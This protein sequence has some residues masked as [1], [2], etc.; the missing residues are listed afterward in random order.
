MTLNREE[1]EI[2]RNALMLQESAMLKDCEAYKAQKDTEA[3]ND[4]IN[5]WR[6]TH[7]LGEKVFDE[8]VKIQTP[9]ERDADADYRGNDAIE[10]INYL[11]KVTAG[12][13]TGNTTV[14]VETPSDTSALCPDELCPVASAWYDELQDTVRIS[15]E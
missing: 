9:K 11:L 5:G 4:C 7:K 3:R 15:F 13:N 12:A 6:K 14:T 10:F 1:L 8:I 2:I